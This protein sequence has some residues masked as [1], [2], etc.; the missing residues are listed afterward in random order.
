MSLSQNW[1]KKRI[2]ESRDYQ[3]EAYSR[4]NELV[5][6]E[7]HGKRVILTDDTE[8][9]EFVSCSYLGL[10]L[11]P[12]ILQACSN[13]LEKLGITFS[14]A[15]TRLKVQS[16]SILEEQLN[17]IFC[18]SHSIL[19]SSLHVGHLGFLPLL[20]SGELPSFPLKQKGPLFL[21]DKTAHASIKINRALLE[22]FGQVLQVDIN[23]LNYIESLL[24]KAYKFERTPIMISDSIKS[25]GGL[26]P[27]VSLLELAEKYHGYVYLDDAHG[28]SIYGKYGCGYVLD[29]LKNVFHPRLALASSL[30]KAFGSSGGVISLPKIE[31]IKMMKSFSST[32][33]FGGPPGLPIVNAAIA[34]AN[35]HLSGKILPLQEKLWENVRYFDLSFKKL[36]DYVLNYG[37]PIPIRGI[38]IGDEFKTISYG[39]ELRRRGFAVTTAVYPTVAKSQGLLRINLSAMHTE[40][41]INELRANIFEILG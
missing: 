19:F 7:R 1:Y 13:D 25:M 17:Q 36:H 16:F 14:S 10:D 5:I 3:Y 20:A 23:D 41:D 32:Y 8:L 34:S 24:K 39:A 18:N 31:D 6:K 30:S 28:T 40:K 22:Q 37:L 15:R 33:V 27:V 29:C 38:V 26:V 9:I 11:N 35:M 21:L 12:N 2:Q 4:V